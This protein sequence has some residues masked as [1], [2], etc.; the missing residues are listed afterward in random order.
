MQQLGTL[1]MEFGDFLIWFG[2]IWL[3][4]SVA[5]MVLEMLVSWWLHQRIS[6]EL[7]DVGNALDEER[8]IALTVEQD[9]DQYFCYNSITKD[10]VCQGRDLEEIKQRF[11]ERYP[12]KDAAIYNGDESAVVALKTQLTELKEKGIQS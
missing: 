4:T 3:G 2:A 1:I 5:I 6:Q 12:D 9:H 7:T 8:L 10:F 11:R